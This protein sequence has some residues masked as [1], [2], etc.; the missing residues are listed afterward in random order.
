MS[1]RETGY[2]IEAYDKSLQDGRPMWLRLVDTGDSVL[3]TW[4]V[5]SCVALRFARPGDAAMFAR[6]YPAMCCL[7]KITEHIWG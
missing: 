7:A 2:L 1:D 4:T 6:L 5:D 3:P